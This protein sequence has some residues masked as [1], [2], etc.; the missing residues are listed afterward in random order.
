MLIESFL[1]KYNRAI[2]GFS[3]YCIIMPP[4]F[5]QHIFVFFCCLTAAINISACATKYQSEG[6]RMN[7]KIVQSIKQGSDNKKTVVKKLGSPSSKAAF[8]NKTWLY[9]SKENKEKSFFSQETLE[10]QVL[11]ITFN[12][13]GTVKDVRYYTLQDGQPVLPVKRTTPSPGRKLRILEQLFGNL[14]RISAGN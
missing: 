6:Y 4:T 11:A 7:S 10:Q 5:S 14:G 1:N 3:V 13:S 9:I 2:V 8:N 12:E